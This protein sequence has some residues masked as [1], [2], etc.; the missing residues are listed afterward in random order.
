MIEGSCRCKICGAPVILKQKTYGIATNLY[1]ECCPS[2]GRRNKHYDNIISERIYTKGAAAPPP[3][4][5]A[6]AVAKIDGRKAP[7]ENAAKNYLINSLLWLAAQQLGLGSES[8]L[9]FLGMLGMKAT[10]GNRT[11]WK[12]IQELVGTAEEKVMQE[13]LAEKSRPHEPRL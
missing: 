5:A 12:D 10:T 2:D 8:I 13:V 6:P 11:A 9:T 4:A 7:R 1:L 3:P